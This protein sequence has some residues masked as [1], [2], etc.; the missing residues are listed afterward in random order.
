GAGLAHD[1][2]TGFAHH[3]LDV[4]AFRLERRIGWTVRRFRSDE[5]A[6]HRPEPPAYAAREGNR[7]SG[8][9]RG[10]RR[11]REPA[12]RPRFRRRALKRVEIAGG[13]PL[14]RE[15]RPDVRDP[16]H[17]T[18]TCSR[19]AH[20]HG[21]CTKPLRS[22]D[23]AYTIDGPCSMVNVSAGSWRS[24]IAAWSQMQSATW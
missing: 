19:T 24:K 7:L 11:K 21:T 18:S 15:R 2:L 14:A 23:I 17:P 4:T 1:R 3:L 8:R 16:R 12:V 20:A 9:A 10:W 5:R 6:L 13:S 22:P